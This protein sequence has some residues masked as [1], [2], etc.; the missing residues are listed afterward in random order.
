MTKP[1]NCLSSLVLILAARE[2]GTI[3]IEAEAHYV[4]KQL[5]TV[6]TVDAVGYYSCWHNVLDSYNTYSH[7][8]DTHCIRR[9]HL[10]EMGNGNTLVLA[11]AVDKG[12][13]SIEKMSRTGL[14]DDPSRVRV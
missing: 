8:N 3:W 6:M 1:K 12:K 13:P 2:I 14:F 4:A 7:D 9:S 10:D 5:A 11:N